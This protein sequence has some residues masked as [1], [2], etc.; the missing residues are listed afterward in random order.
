MSS[1]EES[2]TC[3]RTHQQARWK[4]DHISIENNT[5]AEEIVDPQV[6]SDIEDIIDPPE[7]EIDRHSDPEENST[8][9]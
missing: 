5:V 3:I 7:Q 8:V 2:Y 4:L 1:D 9:L 6:L